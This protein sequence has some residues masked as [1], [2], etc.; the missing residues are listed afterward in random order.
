MENYI[1]KSHIHKS[2]NDE[3]KKNQNKESKRFAPVLH[4]KGVFKRTPNAESLLAQHERNTSGL[5][6]AAAAGTLQS[7]AMG[8]TSPYT[9]H[10]TRLSPLL[11]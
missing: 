6:S 11:P 10:R 7:T 8:L 5:F 9:V 1:N 4:F 3:G 2:T